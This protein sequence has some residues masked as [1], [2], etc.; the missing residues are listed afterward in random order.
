MTRSVAAPTTTALIFTSDTPGNIG[1]LLDNVNFAAASVATPL[2]LPPCLCW[3]WLGGLD[4]TAPSRYFQVT[5]SSSTGITPGNLQ[6]HSRE[7][8]GAFFPGVFVFGSDTSRVPAGSSSMCGYFSSSLCKAGCFVASGLV[9]GKNCC[10]C[11]IGV[12][13]KKASSIKMPRGFLLFTAPG[14]EECVDS[15]IFMGFL[16]FCSA[17]GGGP[18][19]LILLLFHLLAIPP[20]AEINACAVCPEPRWAAWKTGGHQSSI[21][22]GKVR[23]PCRAGSKPNMLLRILPAVFAIHRQFAFRSG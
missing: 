12:P 23:I 7:E 4:G 16:P 17:P 3:A 19:E 1:A 22:I 8:S 2:S 20:G 5:P 13:A 15:L 21:R 10:P 14:F 9:S 6:P 11:H 18:V